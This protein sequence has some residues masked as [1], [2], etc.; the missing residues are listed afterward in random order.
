MVSATISIR[1]GEAGISPLIVCEPDPAAPRGGVS[2]RSFIDV[3]RQGFL[4]FYEAG[5][6]FMQDNA[7]IHRFKETKKL[8]VIVR[9]LIHQI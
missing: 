9:P 6:L 4:L 2:S 3:L 8:W 7:G 1:D 5:D